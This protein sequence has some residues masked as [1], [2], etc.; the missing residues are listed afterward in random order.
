[1]HTLFHL[2]RI[3]VGRLGRAVLLWFVLSLVAAIASPIVNPQAMELVCSSAGAAKLV[4]KTE[5]GGQEIGVAHLD[6][7]LCL[8]TGAPPPAARKVRVPQP[9]PLGVAVQSIPAARI[10][11]ATA[12]PLPARGPPLL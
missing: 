1:M 11:A 2:R 5:D 3:G 8:A 10:A 12:A 7:P 4:I 6:C 9:Q